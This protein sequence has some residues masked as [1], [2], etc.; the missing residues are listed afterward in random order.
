MT[1]DAAPD[2]SKPAQ[3]AGQRT[4]ASSN[5]RRKQ[6]K[7]DRRLDAEL[8]AINRLQA[9]NARLFRA[10]DV[11]AVL[12]ETMEAAQTLLGADMGSTQIYDPDSDALKLVA[13]RG[14]GQEFSDYYQTVTLGQHSAC[15]LALASKERE[16]FEDAFTDPRAESD[17]AV[18]RASGIR[19]VL[20]TPLVN[21]DGNVIAMISSYFRK[22]Y[23][24][25]ERELRLLDLYVR[26]ATHLI[27][28]FQAEEALRESEQQFSA[29]FHQAACGIARVDLSGRVTMVNDCYCEILGR[30]R[31]ELVK[32]R[33]R[34]LTHGDDLPRNMELLR[35]AIED[36]RSYSMEKRYLRPDGT[37]VWATVYVSAI[38]DANGT[39]VAVMGICQDITTRK[40][41]EEALR[42]ADRRKDEFLAT[43][44]HELR[45]PLA[46]ICNG[47]ELLQVAGR[48]PALFDGVHA[49]MTRQ[50]Q[51]LVRLVDDLLDVS[52]ITRGKIELRKSRID[53]ASIIASAIETA[54]PVI[55]G[56]GHR[57]AVSLPEYSL[58]IDADASRLAQV[59]SNLLNNAAKYTPPGGTIEVQVERVGG[60]AVVSVRDSGIGIPPEMLDRIF[61]L[62]AQV[63]RSMERSSAGLGIGLTIV[64]RLVEMHGGTVA[65]RSPGVDGGSEFIVRLPLDS[66]QARAPDPVAAAREH[67]AKRQRVLVVDDNES[68]VST[69]TLL[70]QTLGHEVRAAG[71][72]VE[73]LRLAEAFRPDIVLLDLAMPK[74]NG[75]ETARRIRAHP[76][77]RDMVLVALTGWG[78]Q[79]YRRRTEEA[80]FDHHFVKPIEAQQ[81]RK[82]L[83]QHQS[84]RRF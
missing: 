30:P 59:V 53:V 74:Q 18:I 76:W 8:A 66:S 28:R 17:R 43:L 21:R 44:A 40:Q 39:P 80:G 57:L 49:T 9:L 55:E 25:S 13:Q 26:Q 56:W 23:R 12:I 73:G 45:N 6:E 5:V 46:P 64:R 68:A 20:A 4:R 15:A 10:P 33:I 11:S 37:V 47:L 50:T 75:Y 2:N 62:F 65:A 35:A 22:P 54:G 60:E 27:E 48:D 19:G 42:E 51:Q 67:T 31:E 1:T 82:L 84:T 83:A 77:G 52:R 72:G 58:V 63:D 14:L 32:L 69:L 7:G 41:T 78:Q 38:R 16:I 81:L 61:D 34:D 24:A 36:G 3:R 79:E 71:D 29:L 70:L